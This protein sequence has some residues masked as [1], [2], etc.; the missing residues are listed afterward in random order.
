MRQGERK[1]RVEREK[2]E[3]GR[4]VGKEDEDG[5]R[6]RERKGEERRER[7]RKGKGGEK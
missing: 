5:G 6:K 1:K 7:K 3:K 4:K 2:L